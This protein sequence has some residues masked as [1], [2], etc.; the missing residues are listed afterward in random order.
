MASRLQGCDQRFCSAKKC[1]RPPIVM[2]GQEHPAFR[3][4]DLAQAGDVDRLFRQ[5]GH[6]LGEEIVVAGQFFLWTV[7]RG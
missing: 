2:D 5:P 3:K 4:P 1:A 7:C 6:W